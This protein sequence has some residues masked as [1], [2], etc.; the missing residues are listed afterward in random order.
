MKKTLI[1]SAVA[2]AALTSTA[3]FAEEAAAPGI[4]GNI[5]LAH[6][7]NETD[8]NGVKSGYHGLEDG[9]STLGFT[10]EHMIS[11]GLTGFF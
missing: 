4:Y 10:H 2:A 3:A 9:G 6:F 8:L 1:A 7:W 11:E 5:Q